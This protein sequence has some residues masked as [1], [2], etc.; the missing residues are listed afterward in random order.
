MS[1]I[2]INNSNAIEKSSLEKICRQDRTIRKGEIFCRRRSERSQRPPVVVVDGEKWDVSNPYRGCYESLYPD[3]SQLLAIEEDNANKISRLHQT[4]RSNQ[5]LHDRFREQS[6]QGPPIIVL[7]G[8]EYDLSNLCS[9]NS[10][11]NLDSSKSD[12][13]ELPVETPHV[14]ESRRLDEL[15]FRHQ[16][17]KKKKK[18]GRSISLC[19]KSQSCFLK[20]RRR[21][22][23]LMQ[24]SPPWIF[25]FED[26]GKQQK[27][28]EKI[29]LHVQTAW[30]ARN[31]SIARKGRSSF[32]TPSVNAWE[33][34][35]MASKE[36][37]V[38]APSQRNHHSA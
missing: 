20:Q 23:S 25:R 27:L 31:H 32:C 22:L 21:V 33:L 14:K 4:I 34:K 29:A 9:G 6:Q 38:T 28:L 8:K 26:R 30:S 5:V 10:K 2:C 1:N 37:D 13:L 36:A 15:A 3:L 12:F 18:C 19:T 16:V 24:A 11:S 35:L 17:A 7:D